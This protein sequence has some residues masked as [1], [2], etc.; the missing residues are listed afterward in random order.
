MLRWRRLSGFCGGTN[1]GFTKGL[2]YRR[3]TEVEAEFWISDLNQE[4]VEIMA[5]A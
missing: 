4:R 3:L 5:N 1:H 2:G